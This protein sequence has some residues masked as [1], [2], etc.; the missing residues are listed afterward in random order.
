MS[1]IKIDSPFK[2]YSSMKSADRSADTYGGERPP[3]PS[4]DKGGLSEC[5]NPPLGT[6][7]PHSDMRWLAWSRNSSEFLFLELRHELAT[8]WD[9]PSLRPNRIL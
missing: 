4:P 8:S 5:G 7:G 3:A 9:A 2:S 1:R 6:A